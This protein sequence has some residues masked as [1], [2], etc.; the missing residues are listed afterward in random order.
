MAFTSITFAKR[1]KSNF[2]LPPS[3]IQPAFAVYLVLLKC[4]KDL[5]LSVNKKANIPKWI[6]DV[7]RK[8]AK[9]ARWCT[10]PGGNRGKLYWH[11]MLQRTYTYTEPHEFNSQIVNITAKIVQGHHNDTK[12]NSSKKY[13]L[14]ISITIENRNK[15]NSSRNRNFK[16]KGE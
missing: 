10:T 13:S 4:N 9:W 11:W 5:N 6:K 2:S 12:V 3:Y 1:D 16:R 8:T 14:W 7:P 15:Y